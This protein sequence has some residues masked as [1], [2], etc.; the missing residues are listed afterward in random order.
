MFSQRYSYPFSILFSLICIKTKT[1]GTD[2]FL[3]NIHIHCFILFSLICIK[4]KARG[5]EVSE[6]YS[7][8]L[9]YFIQPYMYKNK[10]RGTDF[11]FKNI[12]IH[13]FILFSPVCIKTKTGGT[14]FFLKNIHIHLFILFS[15]LCIKTKARGSDVFLKIFISIDLFIQPYMYKNKNRG[16]GFFLKIF[17]STVSSY[18]ALYV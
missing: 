18:S 7:F 11:F 9:F 3:K 14:D 5:I 6:S 16:T 10:N 17:I 12:H 1:G 15:F 4:T 2:F 8:P 13:C